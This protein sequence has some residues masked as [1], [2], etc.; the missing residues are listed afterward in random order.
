M[1]FNKALLLEVKARIL[2]EPAQFVMERLFMSNEHARRLNW[3]Y[4]D[5]LSR[6]IPNCGTAACIAGWTVAVSRQRDPREAEAMS[7]DAWVEA[8]DRLRIWHYASQLFNVTGWPQY[9][10]GEWKRAG[11]LEERARV[12]AE[13]I[14]RFIEMMG[15]VEAGRGSDEG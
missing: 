15:A 7:E 9:L 10:Q 13:A 4:E 6:E 12:A 5:D 3:E 1:K 11:T 14:D 8:E 2:A